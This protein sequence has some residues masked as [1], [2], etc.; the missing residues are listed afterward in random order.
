MILQTRELYYDQR[1]LRVLYQLMDGRGGTISS[2]DWDVG[3]SKNL[4]E[5]FSFS[6]LFLFY[7]KI[8]KNYKK[9]NFNF[10]YLMCVRSLSLTAKVQLS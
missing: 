3:N 8:H 4:F 6:N 7:K 2:P 9:S 5:D 1:E 10:L